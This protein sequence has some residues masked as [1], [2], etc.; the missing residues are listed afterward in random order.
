M[1][2]RAFLYDA[3]AIDREVPLT[4]EI[5]Q[6][7]SKAQLLWVD[8]EAPQESEIRQI[9]ELFALHADSVYNMRQTLRRPRL[10]IYSAYFH[11][12]VDSI[13]LDGRTYRIITLDF[14]VG[15]NYVITIH[16]EPIDFLDS[17]DDRIKG[18][19]PLGQLDSPSFFAALLDWHIT[20][21][22]RV[23]E[24]LASAVDKL[25]ERAL[26]SHANDDLLSPL[27]EMRRNVALVR[28]TLAPHREVYA[29]LARPD[30]Q[31]LAS[32]RSA[33]HFRAL[34]DRME[35]A[36]DAVEN[37]RELVIGSFE[38]YAT[39]TTKRT[40]EVIKLLT[41]VSVILLPIGAIA[42]IMG[43]NFKASIYQTGNVGFESV[44]GVV[45]AIAIGTLVIAHRKHWI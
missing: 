21:Y 32:S 9:V 27:V 13:R 39:Q 28:R 45:L 31:A 34:H 1:P 17:F 20:T 11:V 25:D 18:D 30:F 33:S 14:L 4:P 22:F 12:N 40:N 44:I 10:D 41:L 8:V 16:G 35:R 7:L 26:R 2:L 23:V 19:S 37:A 29:A 24:K 43:M 5:I 15:Q 36:I 3:E 6:N 38:I 42:S